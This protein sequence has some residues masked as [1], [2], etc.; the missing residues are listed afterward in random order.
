MASSGTPEGA[1]PGLEQEGIWEDASA[2]DAAPRGA[3]SGDARERGASGLTRRL[4]S[5]EHAPGPEGLLYADVPNR[6][7]ALVLDIIVLS[8]IGF[9]LAWLLGGLVSE[10]G[11]LDSPGGEL[12]VAAFAIVLILQLAISFLY[13]GSLWTLAGSTLGMRLLGLRIGDEAAGRRI[14][15]RQAGLRWFFLGIPSLLASLAVYVPNTIGLI[16]GA[17]GAAWL[18]LLL[19]TMAQN[20]ARQ[21]L[22][23]RYA[24]TIVTKARRRTS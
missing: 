4:T 10:P 15:W 1:D 14:S 24:H 11:A 21:G 7:V 18:A 23:D 9:A 17:L 6:I 8:I 5:T 19:Y 13:F 20:P 12:D 3:A 2:V 16:L 22:Q